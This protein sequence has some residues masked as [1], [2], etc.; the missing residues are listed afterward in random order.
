MKSKKC[1]PLM[2]LPQQTKVEQE[3]LHGR[4]AVMKIKTKGE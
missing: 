2:L 1:M 4:K 3:S